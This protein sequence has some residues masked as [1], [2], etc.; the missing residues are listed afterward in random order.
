M[1]TSFE[2]YRGINQG[3]VA[4]QGVT[5]P[6]GS[7]VF[8][9]G[10]DEPLEP[11][12]MQT[13]A[14]TEVRQTV[15]LTDFDFVKATMDTIGRPVGQVIPPPRWTDDPDEWFKFYFDIPIPVSQNDKAGGGFQLDTVGDLIYP[16]ETYSGV[17]TYARGVLPG[18]TPPQHLAGVNIPAATTPLVNADE[19]TIQTWVNFDVD[20][21]STS[22]GHDFTILSFMG[23]NGPNTFGVLLQMIG[24]AGAGAHQWYPFLTN[25]NYLASTGIPLDNLYTVSVNQGWQLFTIT[26]DWALSPTTR[27]KMYLNATPLGSPTSPMNTRPVTPDVGDDLIQYG[28]GNFWG[29]FDAMRMLG[30][31]LSPSEVTTSYAEMTTPG[32]V[33]SPEWAQKILVDGELYADRTIRSGEAR[34]WTDFVVP[35]RKLSGLH[36]VAF[37]LELREEPVLIPMGP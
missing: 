27:V 1:T 16:R 28:D 20:S 30:R 25:Y 32:A 5:P 33:E 3:R 31:V 24:L 17:G 19:Y 4:P 34:R 26:F 2:R 23:E 6:D 10:E 35:V 8:V 36:E 12:E 21:I 14:Y 37:R 11:I 29:E 15:D 7:H 18:A 13:G 9:L 22:W